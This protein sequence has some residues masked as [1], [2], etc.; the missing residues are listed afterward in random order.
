[1]VH[2]PDTTLYFADETGDPGFGRVTITETTD[3]YSVHIRPWK[4]DSKAPSRDYCFS[5]VEISETSALKLEDELLREWPKAWKSQAYP[6]EPKWAKIDKYELRHRTRILESFIKIVS[7]HDFTLGAYYFDKV[8]SVLIPLN[9]GVKEI[10]SL[11]EENR[12]MA[13]GE[14][15]LSR[16]GSMLC[17]ASVEFRR[18]PGTYARVIHD[19]TRIDRMYIIKNGFLEACKQ[20]PINTREV[21]GASIESNKEISF[22]DSDSRPCL[23]FAELVA[24]E[25]ANLFRIGQGSE[26]L[27]SLADKFTL[28]RFPEVDFECH[29][30]A[31][32]RKDGRSFFYDVPRQIECHEIVHEFN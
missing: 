20:Q 7:E 18:K 31:C 27:R 23:W 29:C 21:L 8:G 9:K 24:R 14:I 5:W 32:D 12:A 3:G 28:M 16:I 15:T 19:R 22:E 11:S 4:N 26:T 1:M 30:V 10:L 25:I 2:S 6:K 17:D 13:F